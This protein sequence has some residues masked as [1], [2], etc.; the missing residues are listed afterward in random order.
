[1]K[2]LR[3]NVSILFQLFHLFQSGA[4]MANKLY[5]IENRMSHLVKKFKKVLLKRWLSSSKSHFRYFAFPFAPS[6]VSVPQL[7]YN[8]R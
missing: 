4:L 6:T 1:M 7:E 3:L 8:F 2:N 5:F